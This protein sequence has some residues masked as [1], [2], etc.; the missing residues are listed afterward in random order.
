[1]TGWVPTGHQLFH[2]QSDVGVR[3]VVR[4]VSSRLR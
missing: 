2:V 1:M 4:G 3:E